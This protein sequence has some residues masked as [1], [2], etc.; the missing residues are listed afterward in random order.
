MA[1]NGIFSQTIYVFVLTYQISSFY[2]NSNNRGVI[3]PPPPTSKQTPK[4]PNHIK[5]K[6]YLIAL[7]QLF[8]RLAYSPQFYITEYVRT[9]KRWQH[10]RIVSK[11]HFY[12]YVNLGVLIK[13]CPIKL[14]EKHIFLYLK[15]SGNQP[16]KKARCSTLT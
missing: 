2:H 9:L 15:V 11:F 8:F 16:W 3:L 1:R 7:F 6:S 10:L 4:K 13:L 5:V 12:C 14:L